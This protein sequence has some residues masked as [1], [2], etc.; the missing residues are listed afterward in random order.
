[1][2]E[3]PGAVGG[4]VGIAEEGACGCRDGAE[5]IPVCE[6]LQPGGHPDGRD[7]DVGD[8]REGEDED[9]QLGCRLLVADDQTEVHAKPG[10]GELEGHEQG[11]GFQGWCQAVADPPSD[12]EAAQCDQG[13]AGRAVKGLGGRLSEGDGNPGDG[14]R[15]KPVDDPATGVASHHHHR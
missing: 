5:G 13:Q 2:F 4:G 7:E 14:H 8:H 15:A 11:D 1:V 10:G 9:G 12:G 3:R 6:D